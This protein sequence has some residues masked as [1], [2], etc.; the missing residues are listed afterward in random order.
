M[1]AAAGLCSTLEGRSVG[2]R[3]GRLSCNPI[4]PD[5]EACT[6][7]SLARA[8]ACGM[9]VTRC[10]CTAE[11]CWGLTPCACMARHAAQHC[12]KTRM[13]L[14]ACANGGSAHAGPSPH[15]ETARMHACRCQA[16][17]VTMHA[18][19]ACQAHHT[20]SPRST[21]RFM[22]M[23]GHTVDTTARV[24]AQ[25]ACTHGSGGGEKGRSVCCV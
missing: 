13:C 17:V 20:G 5:P 7:C 18:S 21:T 24:H 19:G 2:R 15:G 14:H 1:G 11:C 4:H 6:R 16:C 22:H 12:H 23:A 9:H 25:S 10:R 3:R 8:C